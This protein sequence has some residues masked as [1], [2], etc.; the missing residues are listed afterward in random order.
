MLN[1]E[2][3]GE[4]KDFMMTIS[5]LGMIIMLKHEDRV[6]RG[7]RRVNDDHQYPGED[8]NVQPEHGDPGRTQGTA[9]LQHQRVHGRTQVTSGLQYQRVYGQ[10]EARASSE[11]RYSTYGFQYKL[12][13]SNSYGNRY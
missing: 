13:Q 5:I 8:T 9:G 6:H 11:V 2:H 1:H 3:G 12:Y 4:L 7:T 10:Y